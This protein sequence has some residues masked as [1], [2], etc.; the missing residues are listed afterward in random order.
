MVRKRKGRRRESAALLNVALERACYGFRV[1]TSG[2]SLP[3]ETRVELERLGDAYLKLLEIW[4][5]GV[6]EVVGFQGDNG[7]GH[8]EYGGKIIG[9]PARSDVACSGDRNRRVPV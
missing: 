4:M 3:K 2:F 6:E 9:R 7:T 5:E 8:G 1:C